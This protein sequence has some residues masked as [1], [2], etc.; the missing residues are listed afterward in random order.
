[1]FST[2]TAS[3]SPLALSHLKRQK[4]RLHAK[5][6][7]PP[8]PTCK[9][10][11][12]S[13]LNNTAAKGSRQQWGP[14]PGS[15]FGRA[16][17]VRN[18]WLGEHVP[19]TRNGI[20]PRN[21]SALVRRPGSIFGRVRRRE[22]QHCHEHCALPRRGGRESSWTYLLPTSDGVERPLVERRLQDVTLFELLGPQLSDQA[23]NLRAGRIWVRGVLHQ[24]QKICLH[25]RQH[26][27]LL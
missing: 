4:R 3:R 21:A 23:L 10:T 16:R 13:S 14:R 2:A 20:E 15:A 6:S 1:M 19:N 24:P 9:G 5:V 27:S 18:P 7:A 8:P 26:S 12:E 11:R 17:E 25:T 22:S